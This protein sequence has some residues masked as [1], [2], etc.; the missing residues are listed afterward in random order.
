MLQ[1]AFGFMFLDWWAGIFPGACI[2]LVSLGYMLV[3]GGV[4]D[5]LG[6][7]VGFRPLGGGS[8][9]AAPGAL[10]ESLP[11]LAEDA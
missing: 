10:G 11:T 3:A 7:R 6:R 8:A 2:V 1:E 4:E 9:A 5:A